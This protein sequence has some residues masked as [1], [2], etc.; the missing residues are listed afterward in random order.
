MKRS[1]V[2]IFSIC[3]LIT[4][5]Q[6]QN[7]ESIVFNE[8]ANAYFISNTTSGK[9]HQV[10]D[11]GNV[12]DF[13]N[14]DTGSHGLTS[15]EDYLLAC[16]GNEINIINAQSAKLEKSIQIQQARFLKDITGD[17]NGNFY[18]TDFTKRKIFKLSLKS[19]DIYEVVDWLNTDDIPSGIH[20]CKAENKLYY[21]IWGNEARVIQID[22]ETKN[23]TRSTDTGFSNL[24]DITSDNLGNIYITCW[25]QQEILKYSPQ[26]EPGPEVI[27]ERE[28]LNPGGIFFHVNDQFLSMT[29][30]GLN[31]VFVKN[32][33]SDRP[34]LNASLTAF[35]NPVTYN[36]L[37]SYHLNES[38]DV[39]LQLY[40]AKGQL[41]KTIQNTFQEAGDYQMLLEIEDLNDGLYFL[42]LSN[43]RESE[44]IPLTFIR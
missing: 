8:N 7:P 43:S 33:K 36:S 35:P 22:P 18:I 23:V 13:S 24:L 38:G 37:I 26:L 6:I 16:N 10:D 32:K 42:H 11:N 21:L 27:I 31:R 15:W 2:L 3:F 25:K 17:N 44:A 9:I 40:N 19:K 41:V 28:V 29:D 5:G 1:L 39:I 12:L 4:Q 30:A 20:F 34:S 14:S